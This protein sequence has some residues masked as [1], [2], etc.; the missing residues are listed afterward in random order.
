MIGDWDK[1]V[2]RDDKAYCRRIFG[3][4]YKEI[5]GIN[6]VKFNPYSGGRRGHVHR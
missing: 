5:K 4:E 2:G 3:Q 6:S 1:C